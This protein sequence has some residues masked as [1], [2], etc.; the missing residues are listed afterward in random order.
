MLGL[1]STDDEFRAENGYK[2]WGFL[3]LYVMP[4]LLF[5]GKGFRYNTACS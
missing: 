2:T 5:F 1:E 4:V 3:P